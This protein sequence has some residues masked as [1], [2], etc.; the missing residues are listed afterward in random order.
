[1]KKHNRRDLL[2]KAK[3][4]TKRQADDAMYENELLIEVEKLIEVDVAAIRRQMAKDV[5]DSETKPGGTDPTGQL[6]FP[7][8]ERYP[9]EPDRLIRDDQGRLIEQD[10]STSGYKFAESGR[11]AKHAR[12]AGD[13]AERKRQETELYAKWVIEKQGEGRTADLTFGDFVRESGLFEPFEKANA[14]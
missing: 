1:M 12:E 6:C 4:Q 11:A 13:W 8:M 5:I 10:K 3:K 7:G 9:Y 14:A 2:A